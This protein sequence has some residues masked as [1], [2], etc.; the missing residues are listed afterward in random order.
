MKKKNF[1]QLILATFFLLNYFFYQPDYYPP[2]SYPPSNYFN[3][4]DSY[5]YSYPSEGRY[6]PEYVPIGEYVPVEVQYLPPP[7][8]MESNNENFSCTSDY[9]CPAGYLC[10]YNI[11]SYRMGYGNCYLP[12][13]YVYIEPGF[14]DQ[15]Y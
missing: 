10:N 11:K 5:Y 8:Q 7:T 9:Q 12:A 2:I 4:N 3:Y 1:T 15:S 6:L 14:S 13:P